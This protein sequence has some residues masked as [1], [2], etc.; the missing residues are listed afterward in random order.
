MK[1]SSSL[2]YYENSHKCVKCVLKHNKIQDIEKWQGENIIYIKNIEYMNTKKKL[3]VSIIIIIIKYV[4]IFHSYHLF[5]S[6]I[7]DMINNIFSL[8]FFNILYCIVL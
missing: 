6:G 8:S 7:S 5:R 3:L 1:S 2:G 4:L